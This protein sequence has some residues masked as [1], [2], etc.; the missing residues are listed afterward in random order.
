M[1]AKNDRPTYTLALAAGQ[2]VAT[3]TGLPS[4]REYVQSQSDKLVAAA[5]EA[6]LCQYADHVNT[7]AI[8]TVRFLQSKQNIS[9]K[10]ALDL[11]VEEAIAFLAN[12]GK[13]N[14]TTSRKRR[15]RRK[16]SYEKQ[17]EE[18]ALAKAWERS[19]DDSVS[20]T[21]FARDNDYSLREF[22]KLL[23][24]VAKRKARADK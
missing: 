18:A 9:H 7:A 19:R 20:K 22:E 5:A 24:R 8:A 14:T 2:S 21:A 13:N 4:H 11:S 15:G 16:A 23:N 6:N 1:A 3:W 10:N 12:G 17:K